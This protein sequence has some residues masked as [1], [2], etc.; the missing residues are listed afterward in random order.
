MTTS[1]CTRL[2]FLA[3]ATSIVLPAAATAGPARR[4][5]QPSAKVNPSVK[6]GLPKAKKLINGKVQIDPISGYEFTEWMDRYEF[7]ETP[8]ELESRWFDNAYATDSAEWVLRKEGDPHPIASGALSP[9]KKPGSTKIFTIPVGQ[10]LPKHNDGDESRIYVLQVRST[11]GP[12][13]RHVSKVATLVHKTKSSRSGPPPADPFKCGTLPKRH[14]RVV[15]LRVPQIKAIASTNTK[16][17]G[18]DELFFQ[19]MRVGPA[20]YESHHQVPGGNQAYK[21]VAPNTYGPFG[22]VNKDGVSQ[23]PPLLWAGRLRN[24]QTVALGILALEDDWDDL[25]S[26]KNG[27]ILAMRAVAIAGKAVGGV[28]GDTIAAVATGVAEV[29]QKYVPNIDSDD[30][31]GGFGIQFKNVCGRIQTTWVTN[32][33]QQNGLTQSMFVDSTTLTEIP[34]GAM[35]VL[36]ASDPNTNDGFSPSGWDYGEWTFVG[37]KDEMY[38]ATMG[39][40]ASAYAFLLD[41]KTAVPVPERGG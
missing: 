31:I 41:T 1:I 19:V 5:P 40:S 30:L 32:D 21:V 33:S 35:N 27:V 23:D 36:F 12:G 28:Y 8:A 29:N 4:G 9:L 16:G 11:S 13:S 6:R 10:F 25:K 18:A 34:Q 37:E 20:S 38:W 3:L 2:A 17:E 39:T 7:K 22:F 15:T 24:G 26:I 14:E